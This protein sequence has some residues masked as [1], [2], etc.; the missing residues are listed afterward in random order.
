M[1]ATPRLPYPY[2][3]YG[4]LLTLVV[5]IG[6]PPQKVKV[7]IDT[8]SYELWV[9]PKCD[10]SASA[11]ICQNHGMYYPDKSKSS[12]YVGGNFAVTYGTGA[13]RGSYWSDVMTVASKQIF[14]KKP[15]FF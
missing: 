1:Y 14:E 13:V 10:T 7:F 5:E 12:T 3:E 4:P 15:L 11:S 8:G 2:Y 6:T 9:N